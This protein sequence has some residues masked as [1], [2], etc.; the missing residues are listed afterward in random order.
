[1]F[2]YTVKPGDSLYAISQKYNIPVHTIRLVNGLAQ[3]NIVPGEALLINKYVYIVQPGD[4][5][6]D[7]AQMAYVSLDAVLNA[8]PGLNP[9]RLQPGMRVTIP[10]LPDY[11]ASSLSYIYINGTQN[12][13]ALIRDFAPYSTYYSFFEYHFSNDGSLSQLN[14]LT[15][16]ETAWN[17]NTVPLATITNL[18]PTGFSSELNQLLN[19]PSVRQNLI[20]NIYDLVTTKGYGGVNIDFEQ[21]P[22]SSRDVF[23][24]F[25]N[26]LGK[27]LK[28]VGLLLTIAVPPKTSEEIPWLGGYDYG[29]IGSIIDIMYIMA[30]DWH[31]GASEPG[32]VAPIEQVRKTI[33]FAASKMDRSKILLGVP[34]YGYNWTLPY[35]AE[36]L[37]PAISNQ[38]AV[39]LASNQ[40]EPIQYSEEFQSPFFNYVDQQGQRHVVWFEDVRSMAAK[41]EL[42]TE[43]QIGGIGAW[44]INLG[45]PQGPWLLTKFFKIRKGV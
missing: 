32:P 38:N 30:Y 11:V 5:L 26:E 33:E 15:A 3:P 17:S 31:H 41:M 18:T 45:F 13:Q 40:G 29:A 4:S 24:T 22:A 16:I 2:I 9:N 21:I 28:P 43:Y 36:R 34:L 39:D 12:D 44:Q 42:I 1:M 7:I 19:N 27:R 20:N 23:S 35:S 10:E 37:A 25:I 14:D 6:Y 8:N